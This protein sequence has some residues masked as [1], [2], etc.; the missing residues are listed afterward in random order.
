MNSNTH[1]HSENSSFSTSSIST[2]THLVPHLP[3]SIHNPTNTDFERLSQ[4]YASY[5]FY[6]LDQQRYYPRPPT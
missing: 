3:N 5:V 1:K 6:L 4:Q 2:S